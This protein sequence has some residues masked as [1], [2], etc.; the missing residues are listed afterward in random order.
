MGYTEQ[1]VEFMKE[2]INLAY[3]LLNKKQAKELREG[4][5]LAIDFLDG[6]LVEGRI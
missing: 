2:S 4:L 3:T 5:F 6:I 1:D